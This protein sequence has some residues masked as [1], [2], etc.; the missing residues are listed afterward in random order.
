[1]RVMLVEDNLI[2]R[3]VAKKLLE[4]N[5]FTVDTFENGLIAVQAMQKAN[6]S[7][8]WHAVLMDVF[9]PV[10]ASKSCL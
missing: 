10:F 9:M 1:M 2:N 4:R 6:S 8:R 3:K 7:D 5:N